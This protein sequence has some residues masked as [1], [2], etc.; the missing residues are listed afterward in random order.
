MIIAVAT[1]SGLA[2]YDDDLFGAHMVQHMLLSMVAPVFLALGAPVTL[3]LRTLP[4]RSR[5]WLLPCC[6]RASPGC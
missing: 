5:G 6:T 1:V 2:A 3:A 4:P